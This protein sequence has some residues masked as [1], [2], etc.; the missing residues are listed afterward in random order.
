MFIDPHLASKHHLQLLS[1]VFASEEDVR[2]SMLYSYK[3]S[4]SG[5][6]AKL[7]SSQATTLAKM[8]EVISVFRSKTLRLHTTRSW[9]FLGLTLSS[10][11]STSTAGTPLQL[12]YGE[13]IIV[14]I[15]DTGIWPESDS[16]RRGPG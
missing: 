16:F 15:F 3:H 4:F 8:E 2:Q 14:G 7:N 12:A 6:S 1:K 13:D 10:S 11:S 9:D 5:F